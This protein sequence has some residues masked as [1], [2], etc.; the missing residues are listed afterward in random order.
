VVA[1][2]SGQTVVVLGGGVGGLAAANH[3]RR[4]LD[5]HHQVILVNRDPDFSFA[6]SYLWVMSGKR[7]SQQI[8]RPLKS[9]RRRGIDVV[10]GDVEAIDPASRTATVDGREIIADHLVVS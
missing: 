9:L 4:R 10:I 7:Q 1:G 6:A 3:L 2:H 8:T 5:R